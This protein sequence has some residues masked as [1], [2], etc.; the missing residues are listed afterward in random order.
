MSRG[1]SITRALAT[2]YTGPVTLEGIPSREMSSARNGLM[3]RSRFE[4]SGSLND[5]D[6]NLSQHP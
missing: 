6:S 1:A 3:V 5:I 2:G 4:A